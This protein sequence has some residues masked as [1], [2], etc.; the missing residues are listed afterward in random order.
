MF[1]YFISQSGGLFHKCN[2][3]DIKAPELATLKH[4][5]F[6]EDGYFRGAKKGYASKSGELSSDNWI[7]CKRCG[8][9]CL[10]EDDGTIMDN[11]D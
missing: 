11:G 5:G 7:R 4:F 6:Y 1:S 9:M 2:S 10:F 3:R 8:K